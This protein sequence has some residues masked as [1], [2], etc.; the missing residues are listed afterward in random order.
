[1]QKLDSV[2]V[3]FTGLQDPEDNKIGFRPFIAAANSRVVNTPLM[4]YTSGYAMTNE[5]EVD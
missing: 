4:R 3:Y 2:L 5:M 1:M